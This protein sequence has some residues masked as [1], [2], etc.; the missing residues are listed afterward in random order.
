[1]TQPL[2]T[3]IRNALIGYQYPMG[4]YPS[5]H[6]DD[7]ND[8]DGMAEAVVMALVKHVLETDRTEN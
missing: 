7:P 6:D 4:G 1:M 8:Y 5:R 3:V 2:V